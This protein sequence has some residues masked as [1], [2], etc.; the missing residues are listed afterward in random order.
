MSAVL[1]TTVSG[2]VSFPDLGMYTVPHPSVDLDVVQDGGFLFSELEESA[3]FNSAQAAGLIT[4][5]WQKSLPSDDTSEE[6]YYPVAYD[7]L[8]NQLVVWGSEMTTMPLPLSSG[9][10]SL[11]TNLFGAV[12]V[13]QLQTLLSSKH[14][15]STDDLQWLKRVVSGGTITHTPNQ[16]AVTLAVTAAASA[17]MTHQTR[18]YIPYQGGK[19]QKIELTWD[20]AGF[21]TNRFFEMGQFDDQN[22]VF[23]RVTGSP[24]E[25]SCVV[26]DYV[27]GSVRN[28]V[29]PRTSWNVDKF[30]GTGPS[31]LT[32]SPGVTS[33][34][35]FNI[36]NIQIQVIN[37][38][39]LAAGTVEFGFFIDSTYYPVH[40][41]HHANRIDRVYMSTACLPIRFSV[42]NTGAATGTGTL[43]KICSAVHSEGGS[44]IVD[45]EGVPFSKSNVPFN[46]IGGLSV[47]TGGNFRIL[48]ALKL[49]TTLG[50][51]RNTAIVS[52]L[53]PWV[54]SLNRSV[55]YGVLYVPAESLPTELGGGWT[56]VRGTSAVEYSNSLSL[57]GFTP[58][59]T[60]AFLVYENSVDSTG[61]ASQDMEKAMASLQM[62]LNIDGDESDRIYLMVQ[63]LENNTTTAWGGW[64]WKEHY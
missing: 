32:Y 48:Q 47:P 60:G 12:P 16:S 57:S 28:T 40:R 26:R 5:K 38:Q 21:S 54:N 35:T 29:V 25:L 49:K 10:G 46:A 41:A 2:P 55:W 44:S 11:P 51:Q 59:Q 23:L 14:R 33:D 20:L 27:Q 42:Y 17:Q 50:G 36:A 22:G 53:S 7:Q 61:S 62:S 39:W 8:E 18:K 19:V 1:V 34:T 63:G 30:D 31:G 45:T 58:G 13:S 37:Y 6:R 43:T 64:N 3:D 15:F 4:V 52:A 56:S 9:G 24:P